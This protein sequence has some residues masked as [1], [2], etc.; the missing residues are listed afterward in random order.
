MRNE[1]AHIEA[2]LGDVLGQELGAL[3]LEAL[4]VDGEST[5]DTVA[6][7]EAL[8]AR[9]PRLR[10]LTNPHRLSSGARRI[11]AEAARG[12]FV[13][14]IDGHCR[15]PTKTLLADMVALFERTGADCLSRP[16]PLV[17]GATGW[18]ARAVSAARTSPFGHST[19]S[20][21]YDNEEHEVEPTSA[22]AMYRREVF[23]KVGNFDVAFDACEDVEFNWRCTHAGIKAWTSPALAVA[24]EPRRSLGSLYKQ[25]KRYGLGRARLHRKH[26]SAFSFESVI[27]AGFTLALPTIPLAFFLPT[28]WRW[29]LL[30][31]FAL[32]AVLSLVASVHTAAK[33]GWDLLPVL[34][35]TFLVI[36]VGLGVGYLKGWFSKRPA[37]EKETT[38]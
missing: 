33:R 13:A 14:Y 1:G 8:A 19:Q 17:P 16:Q 9:D 25:M 29:I 24:Y 2:V 3:T 10:V 6:R 4:L 27:P 26:R 5:D 34:P 18:I 23:E 11:G 32:Y 37:F 22:G 28:P 21:I 36:H 12:R 38:T 31:P 35:L 30:A 15:L 7:A 20:T